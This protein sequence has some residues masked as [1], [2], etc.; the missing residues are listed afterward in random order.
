M[1]LLVLL[2]L[3]DENTR[4]WTDSRRNG[5]STVLP[6]I[7]PMLLVIVIIGDGVDGLWST[8]S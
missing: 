5:P 6:I 1:S 3:T 4:E 8:K 7:S 2:V